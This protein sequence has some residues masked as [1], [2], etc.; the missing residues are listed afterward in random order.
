MKIF[1]KDCDGSQICKHG[2]K[3]MNVKN[4]IY[5]GILGALYRLGLGVHLNQIHLK[6]LLNTLVVLLNSLKDILDFSLKLV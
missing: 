5:Q 3:K 1:C 2:N 4:A 6:N